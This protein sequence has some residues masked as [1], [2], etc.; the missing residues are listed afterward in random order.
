MSATPRHNVS[1]F[2]LLGG[3]GALTPGEL[4]KGAG[5]DVPTR[6]M[7]GWLATYGKIDSTG[8]VVPTVDRE[9]QVFEAA[10]K[11]GAIDWSPYVEHGRWNDTHDEQV[12][13]GLPDSL[14]F[15]DAAS[16]FAQSHGKV[17]FWTTGH[18][19]DRAAPQSWAG[20]DRQPTEQ[21]FAR[22]D[23]FW[24]LALALQ[25]LPRQLGLSAHG[26][27]VLSPCR[28]RIILARVEHAAVCDVPMNPDATLEP[29]RLGAGFP[30][31]TLRKG[32]IGTAPCG[33]CTCPAGACDGLRLAGAGAPFGTVAHVDPTEAVVS[34][35]VSRHHVDYTTARAML[36][37]H[38]SRHAR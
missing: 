33:R 10:G 28:T 26:G 12:I 24:A 9:N 7:G 11:L 34:A 13:V 38:R 6:P 21:E 19:F 1:T 5:E 35:I 30:L 29:M 15:H 27:M 14:D 36:A 4:R 32:R 23:R 25:G 17:G 2:T 37:I 18:L 3:V 22:A 16:A 31:E 20:L 8:A